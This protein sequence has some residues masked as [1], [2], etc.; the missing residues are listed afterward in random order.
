M[1][2]E[3]YSHV[4]SKNLFNPVDLFFVWVIYVFKLPFKITSDVFSVYISQL[5]A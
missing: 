1:A 4:A 5:E 3:S 2:A